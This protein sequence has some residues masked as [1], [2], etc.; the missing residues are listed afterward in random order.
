MVW[1]G[2]VLF[3][4]E[5]PLGRQAGTSRQLV[6]SRSILAEEVDVSVATALVWPH[7]ADLDRFDGEPSGRA[8][9]FRL[10]FGGAGSPPDGE[11]TA[12][13]EQG[14]GEL[15]NRRQAAHGPG[16]NRLVAFAPLPRRPVLGALADDGGVGESHS[17][18]RRAEELALA[19][20]RL[21]QVE[22]RPREAGRQRQAG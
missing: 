4:P 17:F 7:R 5:R 3:G 13:G 21:D 18:D 2:L 14:G 20:H 10:L 12:L 16:G 1:F 9:H 8:G 11:N 6:R 19:P 22:A 15:G